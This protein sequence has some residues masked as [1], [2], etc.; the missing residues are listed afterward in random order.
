[1]LSQSFIGGVLAFKTIPRPQFSALQ[2]KIFPIY[3]GMQ[4]AVP[5]FLALTYPSAGST[6]SGIQGT[7][8]EPNR[9]TVLAPLATMFITGVANM[10]FIRP[11]IENIMKERKLQG[12]PSSCR[13]IIVHK[14]M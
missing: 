6:P 12:I 14:L 4:T 8:A 7:L 10:A 5:V 3:F 9:W 2:Q 13:R 11:A 1:M